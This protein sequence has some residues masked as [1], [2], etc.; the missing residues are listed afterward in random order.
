MTIWLQEE[1]INVYWVSL[2]TVK[3][4]KE[5]LFHGKKWMPSERNISGLI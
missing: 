2:L 3:R 4:K 5:K 1:F